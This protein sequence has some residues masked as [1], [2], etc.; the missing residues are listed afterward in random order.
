ML[1]ARLFMPY[2]AV[3][4][5]QKSHIEDNVPSSSDFPKL[6]ERDLLAYC[7][8]NLNKSANKVQFDL[9]R[10]APTQSG[11]SLPKYYAWVRVFGNQNALASGVVRLA[12]VGQEKF[13]VT[14]FIPA[15]QIR[16]NPNKVSEVFPDVLYDKIIGLADAK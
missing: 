11:V 10:Q 1:L 3:F 12:A 16:K 13:E 4:L 14:H 8:A 7:Q 15:D 2:A 9:L 5:I 6:L